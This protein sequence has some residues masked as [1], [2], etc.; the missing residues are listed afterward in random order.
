[1]PGLVGCDRDG[2][3]ALET[4]G[5][6]LSDARLSSDWRQQLPSLICGLCLGGLIAQTSWDQGSGMFDLVWSLWHH[7]LTSPAVSFAHELTAFM[8]WRGDVEPV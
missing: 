5:G 7:A 2:S 6:C 4:T 1:M 8:F 3:R